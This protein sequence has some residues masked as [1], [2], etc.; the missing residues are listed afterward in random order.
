MPLFQIRRK[1]PWSDTDA[2]GAA[3]LPNVL[4]MFEDAADELIASPGQA[5]QSLLE[6][7]GFAMLRVEV[8]ARLRAPARAGR[9]VRLGIETV[10]EHP[11]RLRHQCE[12]RDDATETLLAEGMVRAACVTLPTF[13][14]RELPLAEV[15]IRSGR[16]HLAARPRRGETDQP[17]T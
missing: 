9:L 11:R 13:A 14:A 8:T 16:P 3:W 12:T 2:A 10:V 6:R 17:W 5:R 1:M 4:R 7:L 15:P